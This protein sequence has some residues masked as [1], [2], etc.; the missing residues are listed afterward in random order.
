MKH[1]LFLI[2]TMLSVNLFAAS[3]DENISVRQA[4]DQYIVN[5]Y[6]YNANVTDYFNKAGLQGGGYTWVA[7]VT[8]AVKTEAPELLGKIEFSPE[9]GTFIAY[10]ASETVANKIK[11]VLKKLSA[12]LGYREKQIKTATAGGYIE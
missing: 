12:N 1:I 9:G 8:A 5:Y 10:C 2:F 7:L 3:G 11:T 6:N 4:G